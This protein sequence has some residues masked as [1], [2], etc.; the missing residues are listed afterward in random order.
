MSARFGRSGNVDW[1]GLCQRMAT[2]QRAVDIVA[3]APAP[4]QQR[5][6][7]TKLLLDVFDEE[8]FG[9]LTDLT[10]QARGGALSKNTS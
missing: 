5:M 7:R 8:A 2:Q 10:K 3:E 9:E 6:A 4:F 1:K